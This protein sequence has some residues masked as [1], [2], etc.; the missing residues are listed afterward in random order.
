MLL[1][2]VYIDKKSVHFIYAILYMIFQ[3]LTFP[4]V[5]RNRDIRPSVVN[6][7]AVSQHSLA[8]EV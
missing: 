4:K 6:F 5:K 8:V 3:I 7:W 2:Y 1:L